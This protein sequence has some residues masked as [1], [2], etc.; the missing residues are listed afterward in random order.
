MGQDADRNGDTGGHEPEVD[1][2]GLSRLREAVFAR[3][4]RLLPQP[5]TLRQDGVAGLTVA[6]SS[7]PDGMASGLLAGVNPI[8]G[9]YASVVGP[10]VGGLLTSSALM[11]ITNTSATALVAGQALVGVPGE[12]RDT[13]LFL[14]VILV[15]R[16]SRCC[17]GCCGSGGSRAS[18]PTP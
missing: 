2:P 3:T 5:Q 1:L 4:V 13:A 11:V 14:L 6:I 9:L 7:V 18:F 12:S 15:G 17:S 8:Y 10:I 16:S